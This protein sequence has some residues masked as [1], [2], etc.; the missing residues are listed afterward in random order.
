MFRH[1][2]P[3][4]PEEPRKNI[5][6]RILVPGWNQPAG[7]LCDQ[8]VANCNISGVK[9]NSSVVRMLTRRHRQLAASPWHKIARLSR[10][11][12]LE[13]CF[14]TLDVSQQGFLMLNT[15]FDIAKRYNPNRNVL[16]GSDKKKIC[17]RCF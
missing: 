3:T 16:D 10:E 4:F 5:R 12:K 11:E 1:L 13:K 15:V 2:F 17:G 6:E 14:R 8:Y 7:C 9:A